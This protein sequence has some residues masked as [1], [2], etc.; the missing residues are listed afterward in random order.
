[1]KKVFY[2]LITV[3]FLLSG[4]VYSQATATFTA[5]ATIIQPIGITTTSNMNFANIDA[6]S[7]GAVI[8]TPENTRIS[9]GGVE[10]AEGAN[11]SAAEFEVT[12]EAGYSFSVSLPKTH[13]ELTNGSETMILKDFTSSITEGGQIAE[14]SKTI[15]VGATLDINPNQTPGYY[16]SKGSME[17]SVNYN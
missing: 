6:R 16:T 15:R 7:G 17:V 2:I 1:M 5:S 8:L 4:E 13:Y 9:S 14:G 3:C 12:G 10:L 11:V